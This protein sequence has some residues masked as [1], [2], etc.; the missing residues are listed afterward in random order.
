MKLRH[1]T[2]EVD[3]NTWNS[4]HVIINKARSI[5]YATRQQ[6]FR[7]KREFTVNQLANQ[8]ENQM[9]LINNLHESQ[10]RMTEVA[11]DTV[12][13]VVAGQQ[14][15][16]WRQ[17]QQVHSNYE[18]VQRSISFSL[19]GNE[20]ALHHEKMLIDGGRRQLNEMAKAVKEKLENATIEIQKQDV[21]RKKSHR[22]VLEDL[23]KI[24]NKAEEVWNKID[25]STLQIMLFHSGTAQH[26]DETMHFYTCSKENIGGVFLRM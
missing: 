17:Q 25:H 2:A 21:D 23:N 15:L 24:C 26:Y 22:R 13:K 8:A 9:E 7:T 16:N 6:Q 4:Y 11:E 1:C 3:A 14:R 19:K 20:K 18:D 10:T 5:C 12:I